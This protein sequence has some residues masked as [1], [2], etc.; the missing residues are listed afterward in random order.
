MLFFYLCAINSWLPL[1]IPEDP[2]IAEEYYND[3]FES[4]L[5]GSE[6]DEDAEASRTVSKANRQVCMTLE[7]PLCTQ[8][9]CS[10]RKLGEY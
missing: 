8:C 9:S 10:L 5:E 3:E 1:E 4:C 7:K 6:E 2:E